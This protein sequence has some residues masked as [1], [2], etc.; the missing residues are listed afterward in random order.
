M[1]EL[2]KH[3]ADMCGIITE[4]LEPTTYG[5]GEIQSPLQMV[6]DEKEKL[7]TVL[8]NNEE[9]GW[10]TPITYANRDSTH[11][12]AVSVHGQMKHTYTLGLAQ[13]FIMAEYY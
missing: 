11:F 3:I 1:T 4:K 7:W 10:I 5:R 13:S 2:P 9:I 12:R 8:Y 6:K